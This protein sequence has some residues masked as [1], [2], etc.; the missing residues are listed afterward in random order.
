MLLEHL[1]APPLPWRYFPF[2]STRGWGI[3]FQRTF[4]SPTTGPP[5]SWSR[6]ASEARQ[7]DAPFSRSPAVTRISS[8]GI[9]GCESLAL[10]GI[11]CRISIFVFFRRPFGATFSDIT[12]SQLPISNSDFPAATFGR[13]IISDPQHFLRTVFKQ[14]LLR[15]VWILMSFDGNL[16]RS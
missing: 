7:C 2:S 1:F 14:H 4:I 6:A 15:L 11:F 9:D 10:G 3:L 13:H 5:K 12:F 16:F 8:R